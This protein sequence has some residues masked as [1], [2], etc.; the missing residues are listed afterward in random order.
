MTQLSGGRMITPPSH[1]KRCQRC[2]S[3]LPCDYGQEFFDCQ[4]WGEQTL[5]KVPKPQS[6]SFFLEIRTHGKLCRMV[7]ILQNELAFLQETLGPGS[8]TDVNNRSQ[9]SQKDDV[10][11]V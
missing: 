3:E 5:S 10:F 8:I 11:V 2:G 9:K 6:L 4:E 7:S 1:M